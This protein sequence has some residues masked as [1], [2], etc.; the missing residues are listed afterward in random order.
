M[1]HLVCAVLLALAQG[2][3]QQGHGEFGKD[4]NGN[5]PTTSDRSLAT[6]PDNGVNAK[7]KAASNVSDKAESLP[8]DGPSW[9]GPGSGK[10]G[11]KTNPQLPPLV[12]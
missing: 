10:A 8:K 11:T 5:Q 6:E 2:Q 9:P 3:G 4:K 1:T 12:S 7:D